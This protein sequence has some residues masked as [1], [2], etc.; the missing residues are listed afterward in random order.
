MVRMID[1]AN[2]AGVSIKTV[3]RVLNNEPH[4]TDRIRD[5][6]DV[7]VKAL[8]YVPSASARTLRSNRTY[9]LHL[10]SHD[11]IGSYVSAVQF[12]A[13]KASHKHGYNLLIDILSAEIFKDSKALT[14]WCKEL[15][16]KKKPDGVILIPPYSEDPVFNKLFN[17]AGIP[18]SRIGPNQIQDFNNINII[19]DDR[20]AAK[21]ATQK[22]MGLG[23]QRIGFIR[24][25]ES[26]RATQERYN[27]YCEALKDANIAIDA[28]LV[29]P[30]L[31]SFESGMNA[32]LELLSIENRPTAIFA[33]NDDMAA[34]V[35]VAAYRNGIKVP[36]DISV[37]GFD[38]SEIA[39][40]IW[41]TLST[42]RQP[43]ALYGEAA[44]E[45]LVK[46]AGK[47]GNGLPKKK[48]LTNTL[49]YEVIFRGSTG[50]VSFNKL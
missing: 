27:G 23:H 8:G 36:E 28:A 9:T 10:I 26:H 24:G 41:P 7:S 46:R 33:A 5:K 4:V 38:D 29:K 2:H 20:A 37:I 31:F 14:H 32:G 3:S 42:V 30:G 35:I 1:V 39:E 13:L 21:K 34:G 16:E 43:L 17:D 50:Y 18:I 11:V 12:G 22:L 40:K 25:F 6:V 44:V 45:H 19:I 47:G 48:S 15:I 49:D